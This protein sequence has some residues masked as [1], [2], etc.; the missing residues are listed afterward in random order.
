MTCQWCY[1]FKPTCEGDN[2]SLIYTAHFTTRKRA[3]WDLNVKDETKIS[4]AEMDRSP[5]TVSE[6]EKDSKRQMTNFYLRGLQNK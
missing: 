3:R 1:L 6:R 2:N 5:P 4:I